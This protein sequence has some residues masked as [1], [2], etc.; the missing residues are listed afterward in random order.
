M[1][2][3]DKEFEAPPPLVELGVP[4]DL[5][6]AGGFGQ[7]QEL[8][9]PPDT[10]SAELID[11]M[12]RTDGQVRTLLRVLTLPL[13]TASPTFTVNE[14]GTDEGQE[15]AEFVETALTAPY[16]EGGMKTTWRSVLAQMGQALA[17]GYC[18]LEKVWMIDPETNRIRLRKLAPRAARTCR[19]LLD[20]HGGLEGVRQRVQWQGQTRVVDIPPEKVLVYTAQAEEN[21]WYGR[22]LLATAYYHHDKKQ[23]LYYLQNLAAQ[24][25]AV[26]GLLGRCP[27]GAKKAERAEFTSLLSALRANSVG[28]ASRDWEVETIKGS[29]QMPNM[30]PIIDHHDA[31]MAKTILAQFVQLG[32]Q[33]SD[34]GSWALSTDQT[35]LFLLSLQTILNEWADTFNYYL[36][37]QLIDYNFASGLY[38]TMS[39]APLTDRTGEILSQAFETGFRNGGLT[40]EFLLGIEQEMA[41]ELGLGIDY[42]AIETR[43]MERAETAAQAD[44]AAQ[45]ALAQGRTGAD[46][47]PGG[48][49][50]E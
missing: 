36:I 30:I 1:P 17:Y 9:L 46:P 47:G 2:T 10:L 43:E 39:F 22:S 27:P 4:D 35:D 14:D 11:Q 38:P 20:R 29:G 23:R 15:E 28:T 37:P 13:R 19:F 34:R 45:E 18:V 3:D 31:L 32:A 49:Q 6:F 41:E 12:I 21:P 33:G 50:E 24:F 48:G 44:L 25:H 7:Q 40:P 5:P 8:Q 16:R 26:P 42:E